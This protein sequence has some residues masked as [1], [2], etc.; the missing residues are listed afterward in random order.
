MAASFAAY[1]S[2]FLNRQQTGASSLSSS[3]PLFY[4]FS[5]DN[6][7]HA[8]SPHQPDLDDLDD[9]HLRSSNVSRSAL[10]SGRDVPEDEEDPYLRLDEED[11]GVSYR[12]RIF[13][14]IWKSRRVIAGL[15]DRGTVV[16]K[17]AERTV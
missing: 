17:P 1:A 15:S 11:P 10:R 9:P 3:Q 2:Q 12:L 6:G 13:R 7:S 14:N 8:G 4:S 16:V 5:T